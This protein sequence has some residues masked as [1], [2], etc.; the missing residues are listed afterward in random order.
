MG[1]SIAAHARDK[2]S[3]DLMYDYLEKHYREPFKVFGGEAAY[4]HYATGK[5]LSYDHHRLAIGFD[6][7]ACEP[8]R[9]YIF[10]V[11]KWMVLKIGDTREYIGLGP[12]PTFYYDGGYCAADRWPLLIKAVWK[13]KVPKEWAWCVVND[14][15]HRSSLHKYKGVPRYDEA[16]AVGKKAFLKEKSDNMKALCGYSLVEIDKIL[17]RELKRLDRLWKEYTKFEG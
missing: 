11:T 15:G 3:R 9:D 7:N 2:R 16:D 5:D 14:V 12:V 4:S 13:N 6:Y 17:L 1:Y 10:A 8:E